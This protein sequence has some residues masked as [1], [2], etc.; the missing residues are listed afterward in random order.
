M[1]PAVLPALTSILAAVFA[2]MLL[3]QW[4]DRRHGFQLVWAFGMLCYAIGAGAEAVAA[5][6]GW[7][8]GIYR[9]WYLTGAIWTAGWLGLGTAFLLGR[10]RFG[11]TYAVLLLFG[12]FITFIIR[13]S[14]TYQ[15]AGVLP[16]LYLFGGDHPVAR[17]RRSRRTSRTRAGPGS[18]RGAI[19][20]GRRCCRSCWW[21]WPR[22]CP[23]PATR[24]APRPASPPAR[25]CPA[26]SGC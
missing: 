8:E 26:T 14:P 4:R 23:P 10:T 3:D 16:I 20:R 24:S 17:D 21:S 13:N 2:V 22:P 18:R 11:Y 19:D 6:D 12:A 15:G 7:N 1:S 25:R 5:A 9:A